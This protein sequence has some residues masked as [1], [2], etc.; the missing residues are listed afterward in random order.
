MTTLIELINIALDND[1]D[2]EIWHG[3]TT[4]ADKRTRTKMKIEIAGAPAVIIAFGDRKHGQLVSSISLSDNMKVPVKQEHLLAAMQQ[5]KTPNQWRRDPDKTEPIHLNLQAHGTHVSLRGV[6]D[7]DNR[8]T[9]RNF[10]YSNGAGAYESEPTI[11][12]IVTDY[13]DVLPE[14]GTEAS[15]EG[16]YEYPNVIRVNP[17]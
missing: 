12:Q 13:P 17:N 11:Y 15:L 4:H 7:S 3:E 10:F 9:V 2:F 8:F 6:L 14:F 5:N 16:Q 1:V